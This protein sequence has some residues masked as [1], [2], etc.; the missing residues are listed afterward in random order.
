MASND[1]FLQD[2]GTFPEIDID[3]TGLDDMMK[4]DFSFLAD[5]ENMDFSFLDDM[6]TDRTFKELE[7]LQEDFNKWLTAPTEQKI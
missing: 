1:D 3:F 4:I 7:H 6:N 2:L 5:F